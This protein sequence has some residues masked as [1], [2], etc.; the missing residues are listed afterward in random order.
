M[1]CMGNICRSPMAEAVARQ[2]VA[3]AG[4]SARLAFDSAGTHANHVGGRPD[5]RAAAA[6]IRRGYKVGNLRS[7][8]ITPADFQRFDVI[9]AMDNANFAELRRFCPPEHTRKLDLFL[10]QVDG[11]PQP[12][13][14]DPYFGSVQGFERVMDLCEAGA[15]A[16]INRLK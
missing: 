9:L 14:P 5:P 15:S 7:R 1:V 4:L 11:L 16:L 8:R 10:A 6:L 3:N 2:M 13:V 12:E